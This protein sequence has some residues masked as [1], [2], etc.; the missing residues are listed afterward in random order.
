VN[1]RSVIPFLVLA[2]MLGGATPAAQVGRSLCADCHFAQTDAPNRQHLDA[3]SLS[4]H[5]RADVGC[6]RCHGGDPTTTERFQAHQGILRSS[7]PSSPVFRA[8]LPRTCGQCHI[9]PFVQFQQSEHYALL[10]DNDRRGPTCTTC[11]DSVSARLASPSGLAQRCEQCHGPNG[12]EP[13]EGRSEQ[14]RLM[15]EGIS[16]VRASLEAARHLIDRVNDP[17]RRQQLQE[18]LEQA[19]VPLTQARE[20]GH[21]FVFDELESRL[22]VARQRAGVLMQLLVDPPR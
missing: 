22:S 14:A 15:L 8:N 20:A 17:S 4:P 19:E 1:L 11:H 18:G 6:E 3:W 21:R 9:G 7:N 16:D 5:G 12:R 2:C 13:R 10:N